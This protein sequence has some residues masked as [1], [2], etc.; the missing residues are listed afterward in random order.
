MTGLLITHR[1]AGLASR[2]CKDLP[3]THEPARLG[4]LSHRVTA[5]YFLGSR[6]S[7]RFLVW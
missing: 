6:L 4:P 2:T 1:K 5:W 3:W 7:R